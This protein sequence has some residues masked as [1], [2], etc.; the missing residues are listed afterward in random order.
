[1]LT[2]ATTHHVDVD[3]DV[4]GELM[5]NTVAIDVQEI[6]GCPRDQKNRGTDDSYP[7]KLHRT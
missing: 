2:C 6:N 3:V 5:R 7:Q 4:D 1:M